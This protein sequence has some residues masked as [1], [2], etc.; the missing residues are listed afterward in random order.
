VKVLA[1]GAH[2]DDVELGAAGTLARHSEL[3]DEVHVLILTRG[4]RSGANRVGEAMASAKLLRYTTVKIGR[5]PDTRVSDGAETIDLIH[6]RI[7]SVAPDRI[8]CHSVKDSHQ[9]HRNAARACISACRNGGVPQM[10]HYASPSRQVVDFRP[11]FF[12]DVTKWI[13][14]KVKALSLFR[15][16]KKKH[17]MTDEATKGIAAY[18]GYVIGTDF[19][20][21]FEVGKWVEI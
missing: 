11:D 16:Q 4:E 17:Y 18:W 21:C 9:D 5:L 7:E 13:G 15:S 3:G 10:V 8:Y 6:R 2:P 19:A 1:I 14:L 12:V 20:E